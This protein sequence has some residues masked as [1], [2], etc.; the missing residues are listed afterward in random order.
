MRTGGLVLLLAL[1]VPAAWGQ[2]GPGPPAT[3][4][5]VPQADLFSN[6]VRV[7]APAGDS[8]WIGPLLTLYREASGELLASDN[9]ALLDGDNI[10]FSAAARNGTPRGDLVWAGL[11]FDTGGGEPGAGG[12]LVSTD[13]G[14]SFARR[15]DQLDAPTDTALSYGISTVPARPVTQQ[16]GS[17]PQD[18]ALG[19]AGDTVWVAGNRSGVRWTAD[20]GETWTRTVLP[21]DTLQSVDP[22]T[23][24]DVFV[25]PPLEDGRG[26][27]NH[28]GFSV[29]VDETGTVWAGTVGGVNRAR[30]G[31]VTPDGRRAWR[32]FDRSTAPQGP[33]GN[34]VVA[35]AE[36]PRPGARNPVWMAAW[37]TEETPADGPPQRFGVAVTADGGQSFRQ[38]LIGERI[39]DVAARPGRVYAAGETGLFVS[40]DQGRTWQSVE[41][42]PLR[43]E[44]QVVPSDL[45]VQS[46]AVTDAAL[47]LGTPEGLLR[48]DR[49]DE[50]RLLDERP[51]WRLFRAETPVNP[52]S[53]SD[54]VPDVS[55]YAYPNPFVPS[56]DEL[57]RIAYELQDA[58]AVTVSIY[59]FSMNR[60]RTITE[61]KS[62]GQQE[63]VW[64]GTDEQGLRV[65]TGTYFYTVEAGG[66]TRK[67]KILV[68]N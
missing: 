34:F 14:T 15:P 32:R 50:P 20:G 44:A 54:A 27:V 55:T 47:W 7:L 31:S 52:E 4:A 22:A 2:E 37:A 24:T 64:R 1:V 42:F 36:Q 58:G 66:N 43:D 65:P 11:A 5:L 41:R 35:L 39:F 56:R 13:G 16:A 19:P 29:M 9:E 40:T 12:F 28:L 59:D 62:A 6:D 63:T 53:P 33:P 38:T 68:A 26:S 23:P 10:V 61:Q 49:A 45:P 30:P 51:R 3:K 60:V 21:P 18:L 17:S 48:L 46:V 67:G 25:G 57:V 8:L